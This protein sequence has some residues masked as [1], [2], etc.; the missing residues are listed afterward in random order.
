MNLVFRLVRNGINHV[1]GGRRRNRHIDS[2]QQIA[3]RLFQQQ[4]QVRCHNFLEQTFRIP[5]QGSDPDIHADFRY[6]KNEI[7]GQ[8]IL[9]CIMQCS[10]ISAQPMVHGGL[11]ATFRV[12]TA[13]HFLIVNPLCIGKQTVSECLS[14]RR[15]NRWFLR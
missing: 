11:H 1:L 14:A 4:L 2:I 6:V 3:H 7:P 8:V 12:Y 13:A 10:K 15:Q 9:V 5:G